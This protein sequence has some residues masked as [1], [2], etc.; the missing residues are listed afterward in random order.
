M[1]R[2]TNFGPGDDCTWPAY[3]GHPNDPRAPEPTALEYEEQERIDAM[4]DEDDFDVSDFAKT[5]ANFCKCRDMLRGH[6]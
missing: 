5:W 1:S 4:T 6:P 2:Y 3:T